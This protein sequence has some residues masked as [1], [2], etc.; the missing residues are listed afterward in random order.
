MKL[1]ILKMR[2]EKSFAGIIALV[3]LL[4]VLLAK[5]AL[6]DAVDDG[7]PAD[8]PAVVKNSARQAIQNGLK[9]EDVVKLTRALQQNKFSEQQ[10]QLAHA[11]M[12]E[13]KTSSMP[14]QPLVNKAFEGMAKGVPP[15]MIVNAMEAVQSRNAFA[16]QRAAQL[17]S[18]KS[19]TD[20]LGRTLAAGLA[21]GLSEADADK[22]TKMAQQR[23][24]SLNADQAYNLAL[25][26]YQT[27]RDVSRLGVSS[28][29]VTGMV[30]RALD[31][32]FN[33][34]DMRAMRSSFMMQAQQVDPQNLARGYAA[35]IEEGK[36]F[37]GG[38]GAI[39]GQSGSPGSGGMG[40]GGGAGSG[41]SG[42][43]GGG[44]GSGGSGG[45]GGA[46]GSGGSGAGSGGSGSGSGG[47]GGSG[48]PGG[49]GGNP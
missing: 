22:I 14:V 21:A 43:G 28:Q 34:E 31:K 6:A 35:A 19:R 33:P 32:G 24:G 13:A 49:G 41:G 8:S 23:A 45:S 26:C 18:D 39:G 46:G 29:A 2:S 38:A 37:H 20:H 5:A 10:I 12:I 48:G 27:A 4:S 42:A 44:G 9:T 17:T 15:P 36:G 3:A 47:S 7:L 30:S 1:S 25:E 11:L 16:F 40:A